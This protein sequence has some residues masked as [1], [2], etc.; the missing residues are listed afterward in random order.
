MALNPHQKKKNELNID[1]NMFVRLCIY[2]RRYYIRLPSNKSLLL[3]TVPNMF[4]ILFSLAILIEWR[5]LIC[6]F[7]LKII[8]CLNIF[9]SNLNVCYL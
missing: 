4:Y 5:S 8:F 1:I 9:L 3:L 2:V 6:I 7:S